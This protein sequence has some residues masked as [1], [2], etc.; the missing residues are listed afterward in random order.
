MRRLHASLLCSIIVLGFL[1]LPS[2]AQEGVFEVSPFNVDVDIR[3]VDYADNYTEIFS[4]VLTGSGDVIGFGKN[5]TVEIERFKVHNLPTRIPD[6]GTKLI[7]DD[8]GL[9]VVM[10]TFALSP[11]E[12]LHHVIADTARLYGRSDENI[13]TGKVGRTTSV[14]YPDSGTGSGTIDGA[15]ARQGIDEAFGTIIAGAG[16]AHDDTAAAHNLFILTG[17]ATT[18]QFKTHQRSGFCFDTSVVGSDT[19]TSATISLYGV[20]AT[21]NI[22]NTSV[23]I[24]AFSPGDVT[25]FVNG[26]YSNYATTNLAT[27]IAVSSWNTSGYNDMALNAAGIAAINTAGTTCFGT[28]SQWDID[29]TFG[30]SWSSNN[31][32]RAGAKSADEPSTTLD[33]KLTIEHEAAAPEAS[34]TATYYITPQSGGDSIGISFL[35]FTVFL[36]VGV[37]SYKM[38]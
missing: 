7:R 11:D 5:G 18:N 3:D 31:F 32:T 2:F 24:V 17:S 37:V 27:G 36:G 33:P 19:I 21:T 1:P 22:G 15:Q 35:L 29:G 8:Q 20:S 38:I 16:T 12:A 23:E 13:I 28:T 9:E 34:S 6:G 30:G 26:D 14:I 25:D 4:R 10:P